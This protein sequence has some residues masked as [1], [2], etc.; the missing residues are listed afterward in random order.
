MS[1]CAIVTQVNGVDVFAPSGSEPCTSHVVLT[2]AE[3]AAMSQ[4]PFNLSPEDGAAVGAAVVGVWAI[5]WAFRA[6]YSVL[7]DGGEVSDT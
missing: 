3:Y 7:R 2:P 5:A 1:T 6:L 4:S